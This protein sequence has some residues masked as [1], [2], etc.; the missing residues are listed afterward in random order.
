CA[1]ETGRIESK[2]RRCRQASMEPRLV[3]R[4]NATSSRSRCNRKSFNGAPACVPGKQDADA[5]TRN[6]GRRQLQWSPGLCAGET[7]RS[8]D[9]SVLTHD[10]SMEPRLVCRG[11]GLRHREDAHATRFNGAPACVPGKHLQKVLL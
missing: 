2:L 4:G 10:A 6:T 8:P 1:G 11:N 7:L 3:C 5:A 9:A